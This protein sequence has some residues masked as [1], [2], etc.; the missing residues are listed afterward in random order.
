MGVQRVFQTPSLIGCYRDFPRPSPTLTKSPLLR[1]STSTTPLARTHRPL[2]PTP[3]YMFL[4][5]P[6]PTSRGVFVSLF[7]KPL[8][9]T[10]PYERGQKGRDAAA[11]SPQRSGG[12]R[13][14]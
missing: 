4:T 14:R 2:P 13:G 7:S 12:R 10:E 6:S 9:L 3:L 8:T 1:P 5:P 11:A